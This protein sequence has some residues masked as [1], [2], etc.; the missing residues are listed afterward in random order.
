MP[1]DLETWAGELRRRWGPLRDQA[2]FAARR[3]NDFVG[4]QE[5]VPFE[6][7]SAFQAFV[8]AAYARQVAAGTLDPDRRVEV[9][10][11]NRIDSSDMTDQ[12]LDGATITLQEAATAMIA[13]SDNTATDIVM[14]AVGSDRVRDLLRDLGLTA[15][16]IP[17]STRSIYDRARD[18]PAWRPVAC[19]TTMADLVHFYRATVAERALGD[20]TDRFL[21]LLREEDLLQ[22]ASWPSDATCYRKSGM[23]EPPPLLAMGMAGAFDID[24]EVTAF[25]FALNVDFPEDAAYEDSPL[26]P[27][28][29]VFSEGMRHGLRALAGGA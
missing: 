6:V 3:G 17:D 12:L 5:D 21:S 8:A 24:G 13:V 15:T 23:V 7:G 10:R 20:A 16:T 1:I 14:A 18:E 27:I 19:R 25:A 2:A 29:R 28:T 22:G 9:T 4:Y 26:E 11:E